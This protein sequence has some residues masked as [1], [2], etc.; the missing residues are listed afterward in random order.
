MQIENTNLKTRCKGLE[1]KYKNSEIK[2][3][4]AFKEVANNYIE[5]MDWKIRHMYKTKELERAE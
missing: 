5:E 4:Q 1:I 2:Q 3:E